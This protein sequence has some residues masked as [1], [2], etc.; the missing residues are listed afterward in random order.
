MLKQSEV[1]DSLSRCKWR[2]R[3]DVVVNDVEIH[4]R[5]TLLLLSLLDF[6]L[7]LLLL[8]F[9]LLYF[10][11]KFVAVRVASRREKKSVT[12]EPVSMMSMMTAD[13][14]ERASEY[15]DSRLN[16]MFS[17]RSR[18]LSKEKYWHSKMARGRGRSKRTVDT[19]PSS[20]IQKK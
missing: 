13:C 4:I 3:N 1:G 15:N 6:T 19:Y 7:L 16:P 11:R 18:R 2:I 10:L 17:S 20:S 5:D 12:R 14:R 8:D 9:T